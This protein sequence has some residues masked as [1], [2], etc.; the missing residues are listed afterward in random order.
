MYLKASD[1]SFEEVNLSDEEVKT[2]FFS[3]KDD[4]SSRFDEINC[5]IVN[6]NFNSLLVPLK[7]IFDLSLKSGTFPEKMKIVRVTPVFKSGNTSLMT[8]YR[9]ISVLPCFSKMLERIMYNR[10]YKYLTENN[11]LYCKQFGFQKGHSP[12]HA[13]LQLFEQINQSFDKSEFT[14]GVFVDLSKALDTVDHQILLKKLEYYGIAGNNLGWFEK[15]LKNQQ[16]FVSFEHNSTKKATV[17]CGVPQ[18][19]IL[20]LLLFLLNVN[21]LHHASKVLN[22]IMFADDTNLFFSHSGIDILFEKINKE[23][24]NVSN[25][26][27]ANKLLLNVKKTKF[28][29]FQKSSEKDNIPLRLP[30]LNIIGFNIERESSI[31]F[32]G[33]WIDENLS[34]RDHIHTVENK[35]AKNLGLLYQGKHYLDDSFLKQIHFAYIHTYLNYASIAWASTHKTKLKKVQSK[36][37]HVLRIIF[38]Q[39]KSSPSEPLFLS[40]NVLN[41]YQLFDVPRHVHPT[42]FSLINFSVPQKFLK[43]TWLAILA[44][45]PL[46]WNNCLS[47]EEKK[48]NNF[49]LFRKWAKEKILE[50]STAATFFGKKILTF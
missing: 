2:A 46:L 33:V 12:E 47:K 24:T 42:N 15:Y 40:L 23:L 4:K 8:N 13:I 17:T 10:L 49:L 7:Y 16:Q 30:N 5:D 43:T 14:L 21:D 29:F 37:K 44:R 19:S 11:L 48:I 32:L 26:F 6:Q 41:V 45:G 50:L 31:K 27:N 25:W 28:S 38:N 35:I 18:R 36:Q 39:S 3:L 9:P 22:P 20:G 34:S 1:S